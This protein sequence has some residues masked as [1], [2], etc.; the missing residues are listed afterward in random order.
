MS[1]FWSAAA[2]IIA[3]C[4]GLFT[5]AL[6]A[7]KSYDKSIIYIFFVSITACW[8][9][10]GYL[11]GF[12]R[13]VGAAEFSLSGNAAV[14]MPFLH[15]YGTGVVLFPLIIFFILQMIGHV[16]ILINKENDERNSPEN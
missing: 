5:F 13:G 10:A 16:A 2:V 12:A 3:L 11:M 6:K 15:Y 8:T 1:E 4:G 14:E 9:Y 7:P